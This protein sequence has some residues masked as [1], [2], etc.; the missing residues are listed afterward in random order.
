MKQKIKESDDHVIN[1][2]TRAIINNNDEAYEQAKLRK[3]QIVDKEDEMLNLKSTVNTLSSDMSEIKTMLH[4][5]L[6][7]Q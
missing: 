7:G 4:Q 3:L 5:L 6:N 1:T 2:K